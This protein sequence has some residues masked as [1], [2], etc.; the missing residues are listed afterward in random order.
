MIM[1]R[2]EWERTTWQVSPRLDTDEL[3][4]CAVQYAIVD[5]DPMAHFRAEVGRLDALPPADAGEQAEAVRQAV[6]A[7]AWE[8]VFRDVPGDRVF[9]LEDYGLPDPPARTAPD[10]SSVATMTRAFVGI[11]SDDAEGRRWLV[12][13]V[14]RA[15]GR[16]LVWNV[17]F[18]ARRGHLTTIVLRES[19]AVDLAAEGAA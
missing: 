19:N 1:S 18:Q 11:S 17:P 16:Q 6:R 9:L 12:T 2:E 7:A 5:A 15:G 13:K 10:G 4:P 8:S 3:A 14:L